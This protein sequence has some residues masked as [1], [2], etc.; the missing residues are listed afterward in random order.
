MAPTFVKDLQRTD[1]SPL[2]YQPSGFKTGMLVT[3]RHMK[4]SK[5]HAGRYF[6]ALRVMKRMK[7]EGW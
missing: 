3:E 6:A 2:P 1:P 7:A 5:R 4:R